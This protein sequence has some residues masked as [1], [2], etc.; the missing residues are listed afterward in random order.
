MRENAITLQGGVLSGQPFMQRQL[1]KRN[2]MLST[3]PVAVPFLKTIWRIG[4]LV[5]SYIAL[6]IVGGCSDDP[7]PPGTDAQRAAPEQRP[8]IIFLLADDQSAG[9]LSVQG[10]PY[11]STPNLDQLAKEGIQF[12]NAFTVQPVCAPSRFA[13][14]SGQY[15]RT[16]GLGFSS[17]YAV[18]EEQWSNT[19]PALLRAAGY[20]TGFIGKFG[21]EFYTFRGA[22]DQ[23]FD[24]WRAHDGWLN[25]FPKTDNPDKSTIK[26]YL[27]SRSSISTEI[28]SE[29]IDGFLDSIP[30]DR[31]FN[32]SV[33]FSAPHSSITS[34]M[35]LDADTSACTSEQCRKMG[36][37]A[38]LNPRIAGHPIYGDLYRDKNIPVPADLDKDPYFYLPRRVIGHEKRKQWYSFLYD[39][40]TNQEH[41]IRYFQTITGIDKAVGRLVARLAEKNLADNTIIVYA[42]DHGLITGQYG[43]GGKALL[44]DRA[45]RIPL[46]VYDPRQRGGLTTNALVIT[47]DIAPTLLSYASVDVPERM[48]GRKLQVLM[49][50]PEAQWRDEVFLESL[51]TTEDHT[52]SEAVRTKDWKYIRY[53]ENAKCPY[54]EADLN[55]ADQLPEFEQLFDLRNDPQERT[56]L[57]DD[58]AALQMLSKLRDET[59]LQSKKL[60]KTSRAYKSK[61]GLAKRKLKHGCW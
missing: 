56:N 48:Q 1:R 54:E 53:F 42:S 61:V 50:D 49:E 23:K 46:I 43:V 4:A 57:V 45:A 25:F 38:N 27:D 10:H 6:I 55:F 14:L 12:S 28:M 21:V 47:T 19:Y 34:S 11:L 24:Y 58:P 31:P 60:T 20:Y 26:S 59:A 8:N 18:S 32:L 33:S 40:E 37:P 36:Q 39:K 5:T 7:T 41:S 2:V 16:N 29:Y 30:E 15:E 51:T 17:P 44:Y 22:T 3:Y 13:I 52:M 9:T 35:Y